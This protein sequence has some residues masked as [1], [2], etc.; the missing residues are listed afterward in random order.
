MDT[1]TQ[2]GTTDFSDKVDK[3]MQTKEVQFQKNHLDIDFSEK[4]NPQIFDKNLLAK[5]LM[6]LLEYFNFQDIMDFQKLFFSGNLLT[7]NRTYGQPTRYLWDL[8]FND[9]YKVLLVQL[10]PSMK[11]CIVMPYNLKNNPPSKEQ[12]SG[13]HPVAYE[14]G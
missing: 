13:I 1:R 11:R 14:G 5:S 8:H 9:H 10:P 12:A 3:T 2:T 6:N 4:A 7:Y